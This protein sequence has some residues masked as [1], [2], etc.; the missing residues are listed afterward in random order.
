[1]AQQYTK[2]KFEIIKTNELNED[3]TSRQDLLKK[4][5]YTDEDELTFNRGPVR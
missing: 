2:E 1:M 5:L 3:G 4:F